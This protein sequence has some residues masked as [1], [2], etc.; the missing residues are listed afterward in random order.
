MTK[1]EILEKIEL[2]K[3]KKHE[4][5]VLEQ[6]QDTQQHSYKI[7]LNSSYGA[8]GSEYY[9]CYDIDNAE[10]I[11]KSGQT[12]I[13]EMMQYV[14]N[15]LGSLAQSDIKDFVVAGDTDSVDENS[16][17]S[18]ENK[19]IKDI[20]NKI[21]NSNGRLDKLTNGTEVAVSLNEDIKTKTLN[22]ET[23]IKN[24]SRR[25]VNKPKWTINVNGKIINITSDHSVMV[26]RND[27]II[28]VKPNEILKDDMLIVEKE[29]K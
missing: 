1:E 20:F 11:T 15:K 2:L 19:S 24:V 21:I 16:I 13:K 27:E 14:N 7:F 3:K 26:Y 25:K 22:G 8:L 12:A 5:Q 4:L 17:I 9:S 10:S 18:I 6:F 23:T 29:I 28:E